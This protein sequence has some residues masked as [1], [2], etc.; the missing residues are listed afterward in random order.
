ML[1][2]KGSAKNVND[3]AMSAKKA[4]NLNVDIGLEDKYEDDDFKIYFDRAGLTQYVNFLEDDNLFK[5]NLVQQ[6]EIN[7]DK[8]L[9]EK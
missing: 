5:I 1:G 8:I 6:E 7:L 4:E 2:I 3:F 9:K